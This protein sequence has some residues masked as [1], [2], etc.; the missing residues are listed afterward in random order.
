[1]QNSG[2]NY[3]KEVLRKYYD[4]NATASE[5]KVAHL[6]DVRE[7]FV[8]WKHGL[9]DYRNVGE[10]MWTW[11]LP[12]YST[13]LVIAITRN[14]L[15]QAISWRKEHSKGRFKKKSLLEEYCTAEC[16]YKQAKKCC[17]ANIFAWRAV[18][19]KMLLRTKRWASHMEIVRHE[20]VMCPSKAV[21]FIIGLKKKYALYSTSLP[22]N[23]DTIKF[24]Y[25]RGISRSKGKLVT[26]GSLLRKSYY[27]ELD[28]GRALQEYI[29]RSVKIHIDWNL[30]ETFG[31]QSNP[32]NDTGR[33]CPEET[34]S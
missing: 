7:G 24:Q 5:I 17:Y 32:W 19:L 21:K 16:D 28:R 25:H 9:Q 13:T 8:A 2:T 3:I 14:P 15:D 31:Y 4:A 20:D 34:Y 33:F 6:N 1:M 11:N 10:Q 18:Y 26:F 23:T 29:R 22:V 30:E 12:D 27:Y